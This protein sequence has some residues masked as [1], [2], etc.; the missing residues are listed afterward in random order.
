MDR[1]MAVTLRIRFWESGSGVR[2]RLAGVGD[3]PAERGRIRRGSG[4]RAEVG[5]GAERRA[6]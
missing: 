3:T 2:I 4:H 1:R 5:R 6:D